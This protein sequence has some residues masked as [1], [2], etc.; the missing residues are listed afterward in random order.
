M[1]RN[2]VGIL[3]QPP[4]C[5]HLLSG[6]CSEISRQTLTSINSHPSPN[7][8]GNVNICQLAG[9]E[10]IPVILDSHVSFLESQGGANLPGSVCLKWPFGCIHADVTILL[11]TC[12][13]PTRRG[14]PARDSVRP[15]P[16]RSPCLRSTVPPLGSVQRLRPQAQPSVP[17]GTSNRSRDREGSRNFYLPLF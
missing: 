8:R 17:E 12:P 6:T 10:N 7:V 11:Q 9:K 15:E 13:P 1:L 5:L 14:F 3:R 16:S 4:S 2:S